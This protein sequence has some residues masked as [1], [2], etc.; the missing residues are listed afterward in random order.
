[1]KKM[2]VYPTDPNYGYKVVY[3][4]KEE[5]FR[6]YEE[7]KAFQK[8]HPGSVLISKWTGEPP[9]AVD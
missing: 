8:V 5:V 2:L 9:T 1:M 6:T 3:R 4:K 7:A